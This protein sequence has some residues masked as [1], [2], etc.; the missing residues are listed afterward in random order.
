VLP[1]LPHLWVLTCGVEYSY[2]FWD[3]VDVC[4]R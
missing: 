2:Y 3:K 1:A 4:I